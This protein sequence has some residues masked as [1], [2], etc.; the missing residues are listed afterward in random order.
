MTI[1]LMAEGCQSQFEPAVLVNSGSR[2][3]SEEVINGVRVIRVSEWGRAASAPFSPAFVSALAREAKRT[4]ILH[5]HHPNPTGDFARFLARPTAPAVMTYH[6]DVVRQRWAMVGYG[7]LQNWM[8]SQCRV[9]MPTSPDYLESSTWLRRHRQRCT[10]V[11]LGIRTD[12]FEETPEV[13]RRAEELRQRYRGQIVLFVGRLRYYKG[14]HFLVDAMKGVNANLVIAGTGLMESLLR[15]QV[16]KLQLNNR[17]HFIGDI[18]DSEK[19]A[20]YY[21][22]DV[23]CMPSHLRS[24]AFGL[25][26]VEAMLTGLPVVSTRIASG[27]PFVNQDNVSGFSVEPENP[28]ALAEALN[29]LLKDDELRM[30]LGTQARERAQREFS[31]SRMCENVMN[32]YAEVL[33]S[34]AIRQ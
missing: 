9:I 6:S 31:A 4:D 27:V 33:S 34:S 28:P 5:F 13:R 23:F 18:T 17:V 19:L 26:Q 29:R 2:R 25:S 10:V 21:A 12:V 3:S 30:R 15:D 24:E 11:P 20:W 8:M 1:N 22:A 32:V 16:L 14:L 7:P